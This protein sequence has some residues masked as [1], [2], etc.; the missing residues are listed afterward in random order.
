MN[1]SRRFLLG[2]AAAVAATAAAPSDRLGDTIQKLDRGIARAL[3][4][5]N[6]KSGGFPDE[7]GLYPTGSACGFLSA[8]I[9][10]AFSPQS[11]Y[12]H[13]GELMDRMRLASAFIARTLTPD[14]NLNLLITN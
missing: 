10:A 9:V 8:G 7:Y 13:N 6:L 5:Q 1:I 11:K 12:H 4:T 14:G 3:T 2:S